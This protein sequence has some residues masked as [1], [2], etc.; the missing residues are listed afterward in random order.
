VSKANDRR[1]NIEVDSLSS[2]DSYHSIG[3]CCGLVGAVGFPNCGGTDSDLSALPDRRRVIAKACFEPCIEH[4]FVCSL[5]FS[6]VR[7]WRIEYVVSPLSL[8]REVIV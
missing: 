1:E 5:V 3:H 7:L 6:G 2:V 4:F 8:R